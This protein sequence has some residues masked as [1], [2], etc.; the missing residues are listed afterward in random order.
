MAARRAMAVPAGVPAATGSSA[1]GPGHLWARANRARYRSRVESRVPPVRSGDPPRRARLQAL[2][3]GARAAGRDGRAGARALRSAAE[4]AT[5]RAGR[6]SGERGRGAPRGGGGTPGRVGEPDR[7]R[8][9]GIGRK[10]FESGQPRPSRARYARGP[11]GRGHVRGRVPVRG[12]VRGWLGEDL[13][14][15]RAHD[16]TDAEEARVQAV[17]AGERRPREAVRQ[18]ARLVALVPGLREVAR[19]HRSA[20]RARSR[21]ALPARLRALIRAP[22]QVG[23][24]F[25]RVSVYAPV[26]A[27]LS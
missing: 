9:R 20:A 10:R 26:V 7:D 11:G 21:H 2:P 22:A 8:R 17:H 25:V 15:A 1:V 14:A 24:C 19:A 18:H 5:A 13:R 4:P 12:G 16:A 27:G 3:R 6:G 23:H